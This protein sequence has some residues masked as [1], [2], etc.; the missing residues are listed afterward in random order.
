MYIAC[1]QWSVGQGKIDSRTK[2]SR[3][4]SEGRLLWGSGILHKTHKKW[5][6]KPDGQL[7]KDHYRQAEWQAQSP[8]G[9]VSWW[10]TR[11]AIA[12]EWWEMRS[13]KQRRWREVIICWRYSEGRT[14]RMCWWTGCGVWERERGVKDD[15]K[16]FGLRNWKEG[17]CYWL[18]GKQ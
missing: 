8:G 7:G 11:E 16:I 1:Q 12:S 6:T 2:N 10:T 3:Q 5:E 13:Q 15:F 17:G 9:L 18:K 14:R 4:D